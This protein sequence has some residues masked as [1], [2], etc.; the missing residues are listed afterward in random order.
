MTADHTQSQSDQEQRRAQDLSLTRTRPPTDVPGYEPRQFLGSGA[1]GEVWVALDQNTGRRVAI[2]FYAHRGGLDWSLLSREVEKLVFL[3]ADRYVVQLLDVGWD[4]DPPYYVMDYIENGSLEDRLRDHGPLPVAEAVELFREVAIGLSHAHGKGVLHCD[5]KP[6]NVLLDE[7]QK[8]R[9]A[10]FGQSRLSHE[11]SPALGTLFFMAPEQA[12]LAAVPDSRWDVYALGALLY[13][14]LTGGPP[15]R[16]DEAVSQLDSAPDLSDRLARYRKFIRTAPLPSGHRQVP[17]MDRALTDIIDRCLA[18]E[19]EQRCPSVHSVLDALRARQ[20]ARLRQPLLMLGFVGPALLLVI[21]TLFGWRGYG[22]AVTWSERHLTDRVEKSNQFAAK[23]VAE[24]AAREL[25]EY[26]RAVEEVANDEQLQQRLLAIVDEAELAGMLQQI[27]ELE[28]P[29]VKQKER[30]ASGASQANIGVGD[31]DKARLEEL[32]RGFVHHPVRGPLQQYVDRLLANKKTSK[33]ASWFVTSARGTILAIAFQTEPER[34]TLGWNYAWR[35]YFHGGPNDL[36][37]WERPRTHVTHS[38]LS[39]VFQSTATNTWKVAITTPI[40]RGDRTLGLLAVTIELGN[41]VEFPG[42]D[43]QFAVLVDA[44]DG[45]NKGVILEHPLF[46]EILSQADVLPSH[47][48]QYR[49][50]ISQWKEGEVRRYQ[51]PLGSDARGLAFQGEWIAATAPVQFTNAID[52]QGDL[53]AQDTGW[54]VLV[55]EDYKT[56]ARP[57]H[58]LGQ[59]LVREGLTALGVILAVILALWY[60]VVRVL[61][62]P[63]QALRPKETGSSAVTPLHSRETVELPSSAPRR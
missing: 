10:D 28:V 42:T 56:A 13:C 60:F 16:N 27:G 20:D 39:A 62:E 51:D 11:Q 45:Q 1:Y 36:P 4:A 35:T 17:G 22:R 44:R 18:I 34:S 58:V 46:N 53:R 21:M 5:L 37:R 41:F 50:D 12:D 61:G 24:V 25:D 7:D 47:F 52:A 26:L 2:K 30:Q 43:T 29:I 38:H 54:I 57:V 31:A 3:S 14:M 59:K 19:P 6:A 63:G 49:V 40:R 23:F 48:S 8:P 55:Q 32:L 33:A 15:H 9:L